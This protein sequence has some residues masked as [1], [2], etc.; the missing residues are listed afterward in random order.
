MDEEAVSC[1][2]ITPVTIRSPTSSD[3][4][5]TRTTTT[6]PDLDTR[7]YSAFGYTEPLSVRGS[8]S[9]HARPPPARHAP[10]PPPRRWDRRRPEPRG[11][12]RSWAAAPAGRGSP[13]RAAGGGGRPP[14]PAAPGTGRGARGRS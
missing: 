2:G 12:P 9:L 11:R 14:G 13:A 5:V 6:S 3:G 4:A 7:H 10:A 1:T 8:R